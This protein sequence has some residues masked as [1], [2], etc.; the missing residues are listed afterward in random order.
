MRNKKTLLL[1]LLFTLIS[2]SFTTKAK[3]ADDANYPSKTTYEVEP[4]NSWFEAQEIHVNETIIGESDSDPYD[5]DYYLFT[6]PEDGY[7]VFELTKYD[8]EGGADP[9]FIV[10]DSKLNKTEDYYYY[11][12]PSIQSVRLNYKKGES[13]Y[14]V[15]QGNNTVEERHYC[16]NCKFTPTGDWETETVE[17]ANSKTTAT[18]ISSKTYGTI[19]KSSDE[20]WY[21]YVAPESGYV[22]FD[23]KNEEGDTSAKW[24]VYC[25]TDK[26]EVY[27]SFTTGSDTSFGSYIVQKGTTVYILICNYTSSSDCLYSVEPR[28]TSVKYVEKEDNNSFK[29]ANKI[30]VGKKYLGRNLR[31]NS[32]YDEDYYVFTATESKTYKISYSVPYDNPDYRLTIEIYDK[33]KNL[34][35]SDTFTDSGSIKVKAKKSAKCY[36][37]IT[38]GGYDYYN[39]KVK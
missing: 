35:A 19:M 32:T 34:I 37:K 20:D 6:F 28:L 12:T 13:L 1:L 18:E 36:I 9:C 27:N 31:L 5:E 30:K 25:Y 3:A 29:K 24:D 11:A 22:L 16:I 38:S 23:F 26:T 17:I 39:V 4:N 2:V 15:A 8:Y 21:K 14:I 10:Y 33:K 7:A